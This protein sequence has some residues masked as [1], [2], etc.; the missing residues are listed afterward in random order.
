[1]T[2][3]EKKSEQLENKETASKE[4]KSDLFGRVMTILELI[5]H[6]LAAK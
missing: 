1:M 2:N 6:L 3:K 4:K 5:W